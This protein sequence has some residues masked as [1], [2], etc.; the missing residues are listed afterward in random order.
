M[1]DIKWIKISTEIFDNRKIKQIEALPEG[2]ALIVIWI[3]L[4]CLAGN[5]NDMGFVYL[6]K[7][8]PYTEEMLATQF[9][10]PIT[11]I[12]L[13]LTTFERYGMI[14]VIDNMLCISNWEK[15]QNVDRMAE[16]RE[17]NMIANQK[18]RAKQK[19]LQ[20][21]NDKS[22]TSQRGH[23]TDIDIDKEKEYIDNARAR[24][25]MPI[26]I[27]FEKFWESYPKK[28]SRFPTE[29]EF[30]KALLEDAN[31]TAEMLIT[32]ATNYAE[33]V[34]IEKRDP[35]YVNSPNRFIS[36][37]TFIEYLAGNYKKPKAKPSNNKFNNFEQRDVSSK[38]ME[39]LEKWL[40]T[41]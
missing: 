24:S 21:V 31:L 1:S 6:T 25:D 20:D 4:L 41:H 8:V 22:M 39:E 15:Y 12:K 5:I 29:R 19:L 23:D 26:D 11:T 33:A 27:A 10:R 2:D 30:A 9:D 35:R 3:K 18:S 28:E 37:N 40:L 14:E 32:S 16:I 7:E 13:A 36:D 38:E 17:Y 34:R